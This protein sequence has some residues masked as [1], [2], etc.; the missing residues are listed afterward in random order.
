MT[1]QP[2]DVVLILDGGTTNSRVW[3]TRANGDVVA[4]AKV[5]VGAR[6][7]AAGGDVAQAIA[8]LLG[9]VVARC[10]SL[11]FEPRV[12][13]AGGM[14]ASPSGL[15]A[16]AHVRGPASLFD[17]AAAS[18]RRELPHVH[19]LP[20]VFVPGV[21]F[22]DVPA[23]GA[24]VEELAE[25]L[26][27]LD[28]VRGEELLC[29]GLWGQQAVAAGGSVIS[30]GSHWKRLEINGEGQLSRSV[31]SLSGEMVAAVAAK[32]ILSASLPQDWSGALDLA[33]VTT[34][35]RAARQR[36]VARAFYE[37][38]LL[39]VVAAS[40]P[41]QRLAYLWGVALGGDA[42]ILFEGLC[43][44][45]WVVGR[46]TLCD[47]LIAVAAELGVAIQKLHPEAAEAAFRWSCLRIL[48]AL[49]RA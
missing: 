27:H 4:E 20:F 28:L 40:T 41:S 18:Q 5:A 47:A 26:P 1:L 11:G 44:P 24:Q 39:D 7:G 3:A 43:E 49:T 48:Q 10:E 15:L 31:S 23:S 17:L 13:V 12:I 29:L 42:K 38:R 19:A 45:T 30:L 35:A 22:G 16:V 6:D 32:T 25:A 21:R 9:D 37:V 34:G 8:Q 2:T 46:P 33:W 36:G 14:V